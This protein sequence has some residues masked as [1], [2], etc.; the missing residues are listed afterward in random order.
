MYTRTERPLNDAELGE[1]KK[2]LVYYDEAILNRAAIVVFLGLGVF[3][4]GAELLGK[5]HIG[6]CMSILG[7]GIGTIVS[8]IVALVLTGNIAER[9]G[10]KEALADGIGIVERVEAIRC[11][12]VGEDL[13]AWHFFA[14]GVDR[15][16]AFSFHEIIR[17][18]SGMKLP[19]TAPFN[20]HTSFEVATTRRR[21]I[22]LGTSV[23]DGL[24][25][26]VTPTKAAELFSDPTLHDRILQRVAVTRV[27][28][29]RLETLS[30]DLQKLVESS[31]HRGEPH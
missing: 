24:T 9:R 17:V 25:F 20:M 13:W 14:I 12:S 29:G 28:P 8:L 5:N 23:L 30:Q 26:S 16:A 21:R 31:D 3:C 10:V 11:L 7:I 22:Y 1:L 15:V 6:L 19:L 27:F 18:S 2:S 4:L